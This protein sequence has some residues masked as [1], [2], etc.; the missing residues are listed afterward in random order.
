[1]TIYVD[2]QMTTETALKLLEF[3]RHHRSNQPDLDELFGEIERQ[4][5]DSIEY[6]AHFKE[7]T[8]V[9]KPQN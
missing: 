5:L 4:A 8:F 1:M 2:I 9:K 3:L 6:E 7:S